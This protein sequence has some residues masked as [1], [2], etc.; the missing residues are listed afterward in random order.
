MCL[1]KFARHVLGTTQSYWLAKL[2]HGNADALMAEAALLVLVCIA[3]PNVVKNAV[4]LLAKPAYQTKAED[5]VIGLFYNSPEHLL[6]F[7]QCA[8]FNIVKKAVNCQYG[9]ITILQRKNHLLLR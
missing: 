8:T 7:R 4:V 1:H 6:R 3:D 2:H 9:K 5:F